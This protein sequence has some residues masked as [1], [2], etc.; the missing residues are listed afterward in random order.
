M[1]L[2][3]PQRHRWAVGF[4]RT[5]FFVVAMAWHD[6]PSAMKLTSGQ[7]RALRKAFGKYDHNTQ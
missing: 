4:L 3:W 6:T 2:P 1:A 5:C 7:L